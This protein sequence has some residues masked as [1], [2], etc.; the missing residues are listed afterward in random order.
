M[1]LSEDIVI[2]KGT[3][4]YYTD[5]C[6]VELG[7]DFGDYYRSLIPKSYK[8]KPT[9]YPA[10]ITVVRKDI[11]KWKNN[12]GY[13]EYGK[14]WFTYTLNFSFENPY[15]YLNCW[16]DDISQIR[17]KLGLP[18]YRMNDCYHITIGNIK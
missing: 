5:W 10:H 17:E 16:S 1:R 6:V 14:I 4:R 8:V 11:E 12:W 15:Y 9:K 7:R 13:R 18:K 3:L 2:A